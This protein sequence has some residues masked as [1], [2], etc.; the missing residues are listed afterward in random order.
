M[1]FL[2]LKLFISMTNTGN[3]AISVNTISSI[4]IMRILLLLERADRIVCNARIGNAEAWFEC[5]RDKC[6][7]Q[8]V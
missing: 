1:N 3:K 5:R 8:S 2:D 4:C 7:H 6:K